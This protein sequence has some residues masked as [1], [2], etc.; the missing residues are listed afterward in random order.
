MATS[1]RRTWECACSPAPGTHC[2]RSLV[3]QVRLTRRLG[4]T[5]I[6]LATPA[7][8]GLRCGRLRHGPA[9]RVSSAWSGYVIARRAPWACIVRRAPSLLLFWGALAFVSRPSRPAHCSRAA[10]GVRRGCVNPCGLPQGVCCRHPASSCSSHGGCIVQP[11]LPVT[12]LIIPAC[13]VSPGAGLFTFV[14]SSSHSFLA[15]GSLLELSLRPLAS[16]GT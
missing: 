14:P 2:A 6:L 5:D 9:P 4:L 10:R 1:S 3:C 16:G 12:D 8:S 11:W 13:C 15:P 7:A